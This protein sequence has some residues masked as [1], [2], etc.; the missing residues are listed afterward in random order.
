MRVAD[1]ENIP[2]DAPYSRSKTMLLPIHD[3]AFE[4]GSVPAGETGDNEANLHYFMNAPK[5]ASM[6][7]HVDVKRGLNVQDGEKVRRNGSC[8]GADCTKFEDFAN[9]IATSF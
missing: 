8:T 3:N 6:D 7:A 5:P 9:M 2:M 1:Q 4:A